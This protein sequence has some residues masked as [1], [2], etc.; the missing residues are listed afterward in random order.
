M[1]SNRVLQH[2]IASCLL[3]SLALLLVA[4]CSRYGRA[5]ASDQTR[6]RQ[7]YMANCALCHG[8][9]GEGKPALG[10][11]LRSNDFA[12][13]LSDAELVQFLAAGRRANHPL[14]TKG[15]DMPPRGGNPAL[16]DDDLLAIV[17]FL[18]ELD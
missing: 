9:D 8:A 3:V 18:R 5:P 6:G 11:D 13:G 15:V 14:N 4:A 7:L 2:G 1:R 12:S 16:G 10:K 17:A